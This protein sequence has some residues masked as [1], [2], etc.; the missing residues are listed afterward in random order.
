V[1]RP[2]TDAYCALYLISLCQC[3]DTIDKVTECFGTL[4]DH[5]LMGELGLILA[6]KYLQLHGL[7]AQ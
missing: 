7:V 3:R 5:Q 2:K 6:R 4:Q 1:C